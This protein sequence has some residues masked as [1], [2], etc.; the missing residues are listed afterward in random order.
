MA[1]RQ[2]DNSKGSW[3]ELILFVIIIVCV[4]FLLSL[5]DS[6]LT[7]EGGREWGKYLREKWGGAVIVLLL[8]CMYVCIAKFMNLRIP[9]LPRQILG[10]LQLYIS[11]AFMLGCLR[12][13]GWNS[14]MTLFRPGSFGSG[15]A[16]FF[17]LNIGTFITLLLVAGSFILS[18]V[19]YGSKILKLSVPALPA[20]KFRLR[21]KKLRR[22]RR[23]REESYRREPKEP[24]IPEDNFSPE[25]VPA[26]TL[27][28]SRYDEEFTD[29]E[30]E[31]V[32]PFTDLPDPTFTQ[33]REP[34]K[35]PPRETP[36]AKLK[37]G[38]KAIEIIDDAIAILNAPPKNFGVLVINACTSSQKDAPSSS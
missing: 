22:V 4:Y 2:K 6:S 37:T 7:G 30:P 8:F 29:I 14:E 31:N 13:M 38:Q 32:Q 24:E 12:E 3:T 18:A 35:A 25:D 20:F 23:K 36:P 15:L 19:L 9:R 28:P 27:K 21:R 5:F 16:K 17:V 1:R 34:R 10:T 11:F 33:T 26:P